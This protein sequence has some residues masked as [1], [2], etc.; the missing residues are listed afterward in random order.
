MKTNIIILILSFCGALLYAQDFSTKFYLTDKHGAKDTLEIG[1]S[2]NATFGLDSQYGE[3]GYSTP[4][5]INRFGASIIISDSTENLY[6]IIRSQEITAFSKKQIIPFQQSAWIEQNAIGIM[7]PANSLPVTVSWDKSQ[8]SDTQRN[9][10]FITD[11][12][13]GG[14]F[15]AG[16]A[17]F[18]ENLKDTESIQIN[19][20]IRN[21]V[22][23]DGLYIYSDGTNEYPMY[24]FYVAFANYETIMN[25][26]E[27]V[28]ADKP[29]VI[30][31]SIT[32]NYVYV[33][34]RTANRILKTKILSLS[35]KLIETIEDNS[36][37]ID[38]SNYPI[39][40]YLLSI[41]T[42]ENIFYYKIIKK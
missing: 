22:Y 26:V 4:V 38:L 40:I 28:K 36:T 23:L 42:T 32:N 5:N 14:W 25:G 6:E 31:P 37:I 35:G 1:Y 17:S 33:K 3:V 24:L 10:S 21:Y 11:W 13:V 34:N 15:D 39:G 16:G 8:F 19:D 27:D 9:Y 20:S 30:Y 29:I 12:R 2:S 41:E 18:K 7:I